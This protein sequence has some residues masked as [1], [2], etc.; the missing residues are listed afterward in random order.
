M[1]I[2]PKHFKLIFLY[3][4]P[5]VWILALILVLNL[6]NPL[7]GGPLGVLVVFCLLYLC[8]SSLLFA[9]VDLVMRF[10]ALIRQRTYIADRRTYYVSSTLALAPV[11]M[12]ALNT[13]GSLD[14]QEVLLVILLISVGCFYVVRQTRIA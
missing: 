12:L 4:L 5:I 11:F 13:L 6:T 14:W 8:V 9:L 7:H 3:C 1:H 2:L 10:Y